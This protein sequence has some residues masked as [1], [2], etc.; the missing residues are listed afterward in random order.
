M[1]NP[2]HSSNNFKPIEPGNSKA[3]KSEQ[4]S[5]QITNPS[6]QVAL[7]VNELRNKVQTA[8]EINQARV[9]FLQRELA[10]GN[11]EINSLVIAEKLAAGFRNPS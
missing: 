2:I 9:E 10:S 5:E 3:V 6:E 7:Q 11:Y 4:K 8:S 1:V